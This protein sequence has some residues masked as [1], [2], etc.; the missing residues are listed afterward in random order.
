M[1]LL[2]VIEAVGRHRC[3]PETAKVAARF[4]VDTSIPTE[5]SA[6]KVR[7]CTPKRGRHGALGCCGLFK[8]EEVHGYKAATIQLFSS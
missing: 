3:D 4:R 5:L 6:G 2:L 1:F 8:I 7:F